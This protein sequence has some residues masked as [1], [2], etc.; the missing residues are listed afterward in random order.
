VSAV[1]S[2]YADVSKGIGETFSLVKLLYV[3]VL[4]VES[5]VVLVQVSARWDVAL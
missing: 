4:V 1:N 5:L 3:D 2:T